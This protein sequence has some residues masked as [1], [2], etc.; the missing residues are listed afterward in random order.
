MDNLVAVV[1]RDEKSA[2]EGLSAFHTL[3][4]QA[5]IAVNRLAVIKKNADGTVVTEREF[6]PRSGALAGTAIGSLVGL[7]GGPIGF[8]FGAG[9]GA[10]IG[11][12]RDLISSEVDV[13]FL[14][15]V[16][17]ALIPGT[18]AV[19]ADL[20]EEWVT[21]LDEQMEHLGG[22]V[23]RT[24][25]TDVRAARL[26]RETAARRAELDELKAE[27][28]AARMDRR[29]KLQ[30]RSDTLRARIEKSLEEERARSKQASEEMRERVEAL[31]R[32]AEQEQGRA[33][34]VIEAR[35]SRLR[36]QYQKYQR[37]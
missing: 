23:F 8:A 24:T 36:E 22:V 15:D 28:A 12:V 25:K 35:I 19:L 4:D 17:S 20:D 27:C 14:S 10:L 11:A 29:V 9:T 26:A 16:A 13:D 21:P 31:Q 1:F 32:R 2:Y 5:S 3:D 33:R 30:A 37:V 7:L 6:P 18:Y 34:H